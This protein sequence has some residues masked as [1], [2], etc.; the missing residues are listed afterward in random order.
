MDSAVDGAVADRGHITPGEGPRGWVAVSERDCGAVK[1]VSHDAIADGVQRRVGYRD[2]LTVTEREPVGEPRRS[3]Q[4]SAHRIPV[5][6]VDQIRQARTFGVYRRAAGGQVV[7][8][9]AHNIIARQVGAELLGNPPGS[10]SAA[11]CGGS[12]SVNGSNSTTS[13]PAARRS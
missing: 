1:F 13:A 8:L 4:R 6:V 2:G 10:T 5:E 12:E 11:V 3:G 7:D 9:L